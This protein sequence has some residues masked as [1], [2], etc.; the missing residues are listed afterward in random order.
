MIIAIFSNEHYLLA[1]NTVSPNMPGD[2]DASYQTGLIFEA[3]AT[4]DNATDW[5]NHTV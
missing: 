1:R 4:Q 5:L 3:H 2:G